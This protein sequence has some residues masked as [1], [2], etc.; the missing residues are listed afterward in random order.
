MGTGYRGISPG[1]RWGFLAATLIGAPLFLFL[2]TM[3]ALG[4]CAPDTNCMHGF[5]PIV[6]LPTLLVT[7]PI[8][9]GVRYAINRASRREP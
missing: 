2:M 3:D 7:I 4:D 8:F 9:L 5:F 1:S 6:L